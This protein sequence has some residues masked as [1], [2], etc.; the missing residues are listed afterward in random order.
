MVTVGPSTKFVGQQTFYLKSTFGTSSA[1]PAVELL[2]DLRPSESF[3]LD[4]TDFHVVE[5]HNRV[6]L[7]YYTVVDEFGDVA[8]AHFAYTPAH[9]SYTVD[10]PF[11]SNGIIR[12]PRVILLGHKP[13]SAPKGARR[14]PV[15]NDIVVGLEPQGTVNGDVIQWHLTKGYGD[16]LQP[17]PD[18]WDENEHVY[19]FGGRLKEAAPDRKI[20]IL[21]VGWADPR[22]GGI[23]PVTA[24]LQ[25][26]EFLESAIDFENTYRTASSPPLRDHLR[27]C[28]GNLYVS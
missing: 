19:L 21:S 12:N 27:L 16:V 22:H 11:S 18:I 26:G 6:L 23:F 13:I 1:V 3:T 25:M 5:T 10:I 4:L 14:H 2:V 9:G 7:F 8:T 28:L 17:N 15:S 24:T 20:A